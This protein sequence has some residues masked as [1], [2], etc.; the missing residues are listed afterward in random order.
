[1]TAKQLELVRELRYE[2]LRH[3]YP[4]VFVVNNETLEAV[5]ADLTEILERQG[6]YPILKCG[7][8]GLFFKG[9]ELV[10]QA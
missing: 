5:E 3:G 9:C 6:E 8:H 2:L 4:K 7:K 10:L 1:M